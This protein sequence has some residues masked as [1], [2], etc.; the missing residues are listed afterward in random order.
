M[1]KRNQNRKME[2]NE[3]NPTAIRLKSPIAGSAY[4]PINSSKTIRT[5]PP[6]KILIGS[7]GFSFCN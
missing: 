7:M 2:K 4:K 3:I 5:L 1:E 6:R